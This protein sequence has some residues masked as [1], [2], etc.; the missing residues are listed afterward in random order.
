MADFDRESREMLKSV[1]KEALTEI[2][3]ERGVSLV[4]REIFVQL[5]REVNVGRLEAVTERLEFN[6]MKLENVWAKTGCKWSD[7][8]KSDVISDVA[9]IK[10]KP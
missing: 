7:R 2:L 8:E 9:A 3:E 10:R 4:P 6:L 1:V 5:D